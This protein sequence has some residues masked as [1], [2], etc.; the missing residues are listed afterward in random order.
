MKCQYILCAIGLYALLYTKIELVD[1][2]PI[3]YTKEILMN[4]TEK[5]EIELINKLSLTIMDNIL[6]EVNQGNK[7][8]YWYDNDN[9]LDKNRIQKILIILQ[10]MLEDVNIKSEY[11]NYKYVIKIDWYQNLF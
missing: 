10:E 5:K 2:K 6:L 4:M 3:K 1:T 8:Y 9:Q 7:Y 11:T